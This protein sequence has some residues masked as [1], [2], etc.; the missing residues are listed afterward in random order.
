M[1]APRTPLPKPPACL[2]S[3]IRAPQQPFR[4]ALEAWLSRHKITSAVI[5]SGIGML[6]SVE[7][8]CYE[9]SKYKNARFQK[10]DGIAFAPRQHLTEGKGSHSRTTMQRL[11]MQTAG[12]TAGT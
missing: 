10:A 2:L 11:R 3:F 6:E 9:K 7:L 12:H 8:E 1:S 5:I 4:E